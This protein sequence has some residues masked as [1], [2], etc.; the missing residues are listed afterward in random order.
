[1]KAEIKEKW[2]AALRSGDYRQTQG[3]LARRGSLGGPLSHCCL[4]VLCEIAA[5]NGVVS[6][7]DDG[8]RIQF[9][10][11]GGTAYLPL[12]VVEW[13]DLSDTNP[14]VGGEYLAVLNDEGVPFSVIA[15]LIEND[16][17]L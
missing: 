3:A 16:E 4:G 10:V 17:S 6:R 1:M 8:R 13:A 11:G 5:E 15:N 2:V 14:K 12:P 9:G 7:H